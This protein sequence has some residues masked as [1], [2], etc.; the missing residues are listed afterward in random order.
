MLLGEPPGRRDR[1]EKSPLLLGRELGRAVVAAVEF[2]EI[3]LVEG[4]IQPEEKARRPPARLVGI[5]RDVVTERKLDVLRILGDQPVAEYLADFAQGTLP[6]KTDEGFEIVL[7]VPDVGIFRIFVGSEVS[8][9]VPGVLNIVIDTRRAEPGDPAGR[10]TVGDHRI[11]LGVIVPGRLDGEIGIQAQGMLEEFGPEPGC[12]FEFVAKLVRVILAG[13]EAADGHC[14][15]FGK[16]AVRVPDGRTDAAV[17]LD[18]AQV[19]AVV[20]LVG[21]GGNV[22]LVVV[23]GNILPDSQPFGGTGGHFCAEGC[24]QI[25]IRIEI[26]DTVVLIETAGEVVIE[27]AGRSAGG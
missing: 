5:G 1:R 2:N 3:T 15:G 6:V 11:L 17:V 25:C 7:A 14:T 26:E 10:F 22:V 21:A 24:R 12:R 4:I 19:E 23:E 8:C 20:G 27:F 13:H 18:G 16:G 9:A